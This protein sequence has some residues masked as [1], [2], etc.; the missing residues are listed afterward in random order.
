MLFH[1]FLNILK[2]PD[3][4]CE[5]ILDIQSIDLAQKEISRH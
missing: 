1:Y 4:S 2:F 5:E 3:C